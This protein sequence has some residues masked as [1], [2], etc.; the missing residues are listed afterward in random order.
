MQAKFSL[1][2]CAA[3]AAVFRRVGPRELDSAVVADPDLADVR[4]RVA[5]VPDAA[6]GKQDAAVD[7]ELRDGRRLSRE[8]RGNRGTSASPLTDAELEQKFRT[9]VEPGFGAPFANRL[10]DACW[11]VDDLDDLS[12]ISALSTEVVHA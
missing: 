3:A 9:L 12:R 11:H 4:G 10:L 8:V 5:I 1:T 7:L 6:M 2:H